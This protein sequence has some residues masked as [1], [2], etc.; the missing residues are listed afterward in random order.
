MRR[1]S[2]TRV[3]ALLTFDVFIESKFRVYTCTLI[4]GAGE[5]SSLFTVWL[6]PDRNYEIHPWTFPVIPSNLFFFK[7]F[8]KLFG[9]ICCIFYLFSDKLTQFSPKF[10]I[11][12]KNKK[13][14]WYVVLCWW[15]ILFD[16]VV[17][18]SRFS[19]ARKLYGKI[20][21][22]TKS[23]TFSPNCYTKFGYLSRYQNKLL[24][25][26]TLG[27]AFSPRLSLL[28]LENVSVVASL[29]MSFHPL[30]VGRMP[31]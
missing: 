13:L 22:K 24:Y 4:T 31:L 30:N 7:Y 9:D 28:Y 8:K 10:H 23:S 26:K 14:L 20:H 29:Q 11:Y 2:P 21:L 3:L 27:F 12:T 6:L 17:I 19:K 15:I 18:L 5:Y 25:L 1:I 16:F